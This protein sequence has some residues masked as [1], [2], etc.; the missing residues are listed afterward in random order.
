M[1]GFLEKNSLILTE[2]ILTVDK[3]QVLGHLGNLSNN[4]RIMKLLDRNLMK[5]LDLEE[6]LYCKEDLPVELINIIEQY[7]NNSKRIGI[8]EV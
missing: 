4:K 6:S 7:L 5:Q 8:D 3:R 1:E 2:Q